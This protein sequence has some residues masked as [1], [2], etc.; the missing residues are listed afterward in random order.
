M[1][2]R[3]WLNNGTVVDG[4]GLSE[5]VGDVW[6]QGGRIIG[7]FAR[8]GAADAAQQAALAGWKAQDP[9]QIDCTAKVIAPGF[10]DV[11][12]HDDAAAEA[13][14]ARSDRHG[15]SG[16]RRLLERAA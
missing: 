4:T 2:R 15:G 3:V 13:A 8:D 12:T 9:L 5:F 11:H 7:V 1:E 14:A 16:A 10:I 6:L